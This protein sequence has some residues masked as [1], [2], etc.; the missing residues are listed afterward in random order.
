[1]TTQENKA[2]EAGHDGRAFAD[3]SEWWKFRVRGSDARSWLNDLLTSNI[4]SLPDGASVP[5]LLLSPTGRIRA[6]VTVAA[7][8]EGL[9]VVQDAGQPSS[10]AQL[11]A[12]YILS[13]D[14]EL[15]DVSD[16][17]TLLAFLGR[18][19]PAI[20]A[21]E[22]YNPSCLGEGADLVV[23]RSEAEAVRNELEGFVEMDPDA[24]D[25]WRIQRG[26]PR[27][28]IDLTTESLPHEADLDSAIDY[29]KG[30]YLGQEAVAKVRNLGRPPW[31][32]VSMQAEG[33]VQRG[34]V[35]MANGE[36]VGRVTSVAGADGHTALIARIRW[37]ARE[38]PLSTASGTRLVSSGTASTSV[39][40][41]S[42]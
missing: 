9:L 25:A 12:P 19:A 22:T 32:V 11:L 41:G 34:D 2:S 10:I 7:L 8:E 14:V 4:S 29:E 27:F 36:E 40:G 23:A 24:L 35:V 28:P 6:T 38:L 26:V 39:G 16:T 18:D 13:S 20:A 15:I 31:V 33:R 21:G 17:L 42:F 3:L 5:T 37:G 30:C 1:V